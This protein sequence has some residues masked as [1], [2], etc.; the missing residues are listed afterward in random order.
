MGRAAKNRSARRRRKR[1]EA[2]TIRERRE[3][4]RRRREDEATPGGFG[5]VFGEATPGEAWRSWMRKTFR[6]R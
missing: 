6:R 2:R 3:R 4:R 1:A 5:S